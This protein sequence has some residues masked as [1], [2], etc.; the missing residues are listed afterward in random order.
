[1]V[2][3]TRGATKLN[4]F[5][6]AGEGIEVAELLLF[7]RLLLG[8]DERALSHHLLNR[9]NNVRST[10]DHLAVQT[11]ESGVQTDYTSARGLC[12]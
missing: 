2:G 12:M 8:L 3:E 6:M 11:S 1:M 9:Y 4:L 10:T 7:D 5:Q